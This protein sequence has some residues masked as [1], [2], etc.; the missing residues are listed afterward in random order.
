MAD[1]LIRM[2]TQ[3]ADFFRSQP[4]APEIAVAA[5]IN[6]Y[7]TYAMRRDLLTA[8]ASGTPADP[9]V[10]AAGPHV[11]LPAEAAAEADGI[12]RP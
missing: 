11:R 9:V 1:K 7:W 4:G 12:S 6:H 3:I 8:L 10:R 5:H 2:A